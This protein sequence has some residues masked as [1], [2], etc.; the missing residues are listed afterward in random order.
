VLGKSGK[1]TGEWRR[2]HNEELYDLCSTPN[3]I[4]VMKLGRMGW[5][6]RVE[7]MGDRTGA[8]TGVVRRPQG[9][10]PRVTPRGTGQEHSKM[11][12]RVTSR[13]TEQEHSK[14]GPRVTPRGT[15]QEH[16]KTDRQ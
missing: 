6:G 14:M 4:R 9:R 2:L 7:C 1:A 10:R 16:S 13:G 3:F 8:Y 11:G 5:A 12:P 15:G